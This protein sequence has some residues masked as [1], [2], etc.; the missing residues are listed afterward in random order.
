MTLTLVGIFI[1]ITFFVLIILLTVQ[2]RLTS[3]KHTVGKR[4]ADFTREEVKTDTNVPFIVRDDQMSKIPWLNRMLENLNVTKNL[5]KVIEQADLPM[6]VGEL[7]ILALIFAFLGYLVTIKSSIILRLVLPFALATLPFVYVFMKRS[8]RLK[9]FIRG[10]PDALDMMISAIKAGHGF[11][12]AMQLVA[13]E[14]P[15]PIGVEFR[16]TFEQYNLGL[17]LRESL[18]NLTERVDSLDL[19]LFV[20]ALLLQKE[21]GGNLAEILVN[22]GLTIRARFKLIGQIRTYTAQGRM[23]A[24]VIGLL[25]LIFIGL[26]SFLNPGYLEPLFQDELGH[27]LIT[28]SVILQIIGFLVIR[29]IVQIKYQ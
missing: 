1:A 6:K 14:A 5:T 27:M 29:K 21:T 10:F 26:I 12:K 15:D 24:L 9:A 20:T 16:R 11:N 7:I 8:A 2:R 28:V 4:L 18:I 25:P 22:I 23:S 19:K 3:A 17:Q 13:D